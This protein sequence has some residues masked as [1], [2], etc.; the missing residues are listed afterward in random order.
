MSMRRRTVPAFLAAV[1]M[2][3]VFVPIAG[4]QP[5]A[6]AALPTGFQEQI[7]YSG[8]TNPTNIEFSPDGRVFV[9]EKSGVIKVYDSLSDPTP[10]VFADLRTNV[11]NQWDRGLL[12]LAL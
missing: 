9:A 5:A 3:S 8:L 10:D 7:V 6:A 2:A 12:G 11:H 1:L 4:G